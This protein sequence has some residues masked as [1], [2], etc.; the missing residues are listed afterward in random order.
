MVTPEG[1]SPPIK[2][3]R[4]MIGVIDDVTPASKQVLF[5]RS[6][7]ALLH[8]PGGTVRE[9]ASWGAASPCEELRRL[10]RDVLAERLPRA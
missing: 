1:I 4:A 9:P 10:Q 6:S 2:T 3:G 7:S 5:E 8:D